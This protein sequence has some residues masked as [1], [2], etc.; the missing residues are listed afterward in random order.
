[1]VTIYK[2]TQFSFSIRNY[3]RRKSQNPFLNLQLRKKATYQDNN[4]PIFEVGP[5]KRHIQ[6]FIKIG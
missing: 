2:Q 6:N 5:S 4:Y 3:F 1:M